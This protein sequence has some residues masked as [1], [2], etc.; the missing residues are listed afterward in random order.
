ML[1]DTNFQTLKFGDRGELVELLQDELKSL[2]LYSYNVNGIFD[3]NTENAVKDFQATSN[4]LTNGIV[5][6]DLW[7]MIYN[8]ATL[9]GYKPSY[10]P[11]QNYPTLEYNDTSEYVVILQQI[12]ADLGYKRGEIDGWFGPTTLESVKDFQRANG[13]SVDGIVGKDTWNALLA[14]Q[15]NNPGSGKMINYTVKKG[16]TLYNLAK[17][18]CTTVGA[19]KR[20]SGITGDLLSVGQQLYIP[21]QCINTPGTTIKYTVKRGDTLYNLAKVHCTTIED[22]KR[23]SKI[24]IDLLLIGQELIIPDNCNKNTDSLNY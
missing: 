20:A 23:E 17:L 18:H 14:S 2:G 19:I 13:L 5:N 21:D 16:D 15:E 4:I 10:N 24:D 22:I 12:L 11:S 6:Y 1:D 8:A 3:T 9:L 7:Q